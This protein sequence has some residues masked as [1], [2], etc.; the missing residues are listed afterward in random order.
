MRTKYWAKKSHKRSLEDARALSWIPESRPDSVDSVLIIPKILFQSP[1]QFFERISFL[2]AN[3]IYL[4]YSKILTRGHDDALID[5]PQRSN[6]N[7]LN[8][9]N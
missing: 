7:F 8:L 2:K 9:S 1:S 6:Q 3:P 5:F 4:F